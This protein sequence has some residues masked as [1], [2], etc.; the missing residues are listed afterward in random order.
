MKPRR[1]LPISKIQQVISRILAELERLFHNPHCLQDNGLAGTPEL[2]VA[3]LFGSVVAGC[4]LFRIA[5]L[6]SFYSAFS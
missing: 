5:Y 4:F 2:L 6:A 1:P 3:K